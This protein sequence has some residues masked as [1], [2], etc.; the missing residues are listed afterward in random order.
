MTDAH[1]YTATD[2]EAEMTVWPP[3]DKGDEAPRRSVRGIGDKTW[4]KVDTGREMAGKQPTGAWLTEAIHEKFERQVAQSRGAVVPVLPTPPAAP[5]VARLVPTVE[6]DP[7]VIVEARDLAVLSALL[8][9]TS[10]GHSNRVREEADRVIVDRLRRLRLSL[11][12]RQPKPAQ[13]SDAT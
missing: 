3:S 8:A 12:K 13:P 4:N 6:E 7:G 1:E 5:A 2:T 9:F 10:D 11:P